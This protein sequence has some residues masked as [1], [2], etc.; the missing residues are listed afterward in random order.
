MGKSRL[1]EHR[2]FLNWFV[3][4]MICRQP[5]V[6]VV[7]GD[8]FDHGLPPHEVQQL[9]YESLIQL[10]KTG[11][12]NVI[13]TGGNHDSISF[14]EASK[15]M[16]EALG[17]RVFAKLEAEPSQHLC[18]VYSK[19]NQVIGHVLAIPYLRERELRRSI[20]G[21]STDLR[22]KSLLQG[23]SD[24]YHLEMPDDDLPKVAMGHFFCQGSNLGDT[25]RELYLGELE[26]V[27][28]NVFGETWDYVALGHLHR[29]QG[30]GEEK[31][32]WYSGTPIPLS[33]K[34][35][36]RQQF[37]LEVELNEKR[38][39]L[40]DKVMI[41]RFRPILSMMLHPDELEKALIELNC[42][43][44]LSTWL[45]LTLSEARPWEWISDLLQKTLKQKRA[46]VL[47]IRF[48]SQMQSEHE[49][50][51]EFESLEMLDPERLFQTYLE[52]CKVD[53]NEY[54]HLNKKFKK[55]CADLAAKGAEL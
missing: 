8:I 39:P 6:I 20:S 38:K 33:F 46:E 41:P 30:L 36:E 14:L 5:D 37:F 28:M 47:S 45:E 43:G 4:E 51:A 31:K 44:E 22:R 15:K 26:A 23:M 55:V 40:V 10:V 1:E 32:V 16:F 12:H 18:P 21:E 3:E 7:S 42:E 13:L 11:C 19:S 29:A 9:Y 2:L 24:V 52:E 49:A 54:E 50:S 34:E 17:V 25:E 48:E 35:A 53:E 27:P